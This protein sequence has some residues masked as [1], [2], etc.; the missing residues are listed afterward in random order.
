M[1]LG[2]MIGNHRRFLH[3]SP[4]SPFSPFSLFRLFS[5]LSLLSLFSLFCP[6]ANFLILI[7]PLHPGKKFFLF[8][9]TY[10]K[11]FLIIHDD[12]STLAFVILLDVL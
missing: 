1:A 4:F 5:L 7:H 2:S 11:R 8:S 6:S 3:F 12:L 10:F 9:P